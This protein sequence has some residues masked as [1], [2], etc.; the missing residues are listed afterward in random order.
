MKS[1]AHTNSL[2]NETSPYLLQH[3]HNP[4]NWFAWNDD[5]LQ[6]AKEENK[7]I[8]I[9]IGYSACHWCHVMEHECFEDESVAILMNKHFINIKID[10]EERP[11]IDQVYMTAVQ[12][13]T[14]HGGWPLN[15]FALPDGRPIYGGTYFS[16]Q[17]WMQVLQSIADLYKTN[18][19]KAEEYANELTKGILHAEMIV[20]QGDSREL[21]LETI[22]KSIK[23]WKPLLDREEGGL[24]K[25]PKF[26]LPNNYVFL[27]RYA[28]F[29]SDESLM[30][31]VH[32][33]L[34]KMA[35][36]GIYDQ[37]QGGFSRYSVDA[38]WK[39][40]HFEKMLYDNAQLISLYA[41]A[42]QQSKNKLYK[43]IV[44]ECVSFIEKE[45]W[46]KDNALY[47]ALD[48]DSEG[49]EGKYYV[50]KKEELRL[51][52]DEKTFDLFCEYYNVSE[53][54]YWEHGNYILL[55][56]DTEK[57]I[58]LKN[59][60]T[61]TEL[62]KSISSAKNKLLAI[63]E[64][65]IQPS[66]DDK[67]ICSWNALMLK[68]YTE[69]YKVFGNDQYL[70]KA[71]LLANFLTTKMKNGDAL[72]HSYKNNQA[73][74]NAFLEDYAFVIDAYIALYEVSG[75]SD[76][77]HEAKRLCEY[78]LTHFYDKQSNYFFF[79]SDEDAELIVRKIEISDNVTPASNSQM[80]RNL[81]R[82]H[83]HFYLPHY[84]EIAKKMCEKLSDEISHYG[85]AYS[86]WA[87]LQLELMLPFKEIAI[88][89]KEYKS[90]FLKINQNYRPNTIFAISETEQELPLLR[91]RY[92]SEK[93]LIYVCE[94][95]SCSAPVEQVKDLYV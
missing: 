18:K 82:L 12:L 62:I 15:C 63:R 83:K 78:T 95:N 54:G 1:Y 57:Q 38:F 60:I 42:Y 93:T 71:V 33:T 3:A 43:Q 58:A 53:V 92:V 81:V 37:L 9:S 24:N 20:T 65:R 49:I 89:G 17:Q 5:T 26:P 10:R 27:L 66:L 39:V 84:Y 76:W 4:V 6:K 32:L 90:Y 36:G 7:L 72:F 2:I 13:M 70:N 75:I 11:D 68:A 85:S 47:S 19:N 79:T 87:I 73:K 44:E 31:Q 88:V 41:E 28:H 86:N 50:W 23:N 61:E 55:R 91:S 56:K 74:I 25:A 8:L 22:H 35:F 67:I 46:N 77:L 52:L 34:Q 69:A 40:P 29:F 51:H 21:H 16:K 64:K 94:N 30:Q 14:K 45:W 59:Q 48:A 80:A